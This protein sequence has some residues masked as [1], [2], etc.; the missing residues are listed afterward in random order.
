MKKKLILILGLLLTVLSI[1]GISFEELYKQNL[2]KSS[3]YVQAEMN[4][5]NA[6]LEMKQIDQ[7]FVPYLQISL[8]TILKAEITTPEV[9]KKSETEVGG[10]IFNSSGNMIGYSF[11]LNTNFAEVFGTS[12]GLSFPFKIYFDDDKS[13]FYGPWSTIEYITTSAG[14][15]ITVEEK[16]YEQIAIV[17]SRDLKK[18]DKAERLSTES[19]Y[20][21]AL[22]SY[23]L[24]QTNEFIN[25]V[26]DIF[27]RYYNEKVIELS[28]KQINILQNQYNTATEE[29]AKEEIE[30]QILTAQKTLE[31]LKANNV[32]LEYFD[33]TED[34][35]TET[36]NIIDTI[37]SQNTDVSIDL[38]E[39]LDLKALHLNEES[40]KIQ[41]K[42]W[43]LPYLPFSKLTLSV[44]P[45]TIDE[46]DKWKPSWSI[47]LDFQLTIFDKGER[48][49]ASDNMKSNLANLTYEESLK[50][51]EETIMGLET[52]RKTLNFDVSI[53]QIDL[54][55]A[56]ED[57][58][59]NIDLYKKGFITQ[60]DLSLSEI[61]LQ[62][63][64]LNLENTENS[65]K[66]NELR[67]MQQ[68]YV[69]LWG[70]NN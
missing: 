43:F 40:S 12:I 37:I 47:G 2:N 29:K 26:E 54:K 3:T 68:Y 64:K 39:R 62:M 38:S 30:K 15:P 55:N 46:E 61:A 23:Y 56:Q 50:Q 1:F 27:N 24:A 53:N 5:K 35:Y 31:G 25:T 7:F 70:D 44:Q 6:E 14:T 19:K 51:I 18:V 20:Y 22:S 63:N 21:S 59:K 67:L 52:K 48:K 36:R 57:Y 42:F 41:K 58:E 60:D 4:L 10:F 33:F 45:F 69:N 66:V 34:L 13:G 65:L 11:S 32:S 16:L 28:Q 9:T 8:N 49:L 17:A